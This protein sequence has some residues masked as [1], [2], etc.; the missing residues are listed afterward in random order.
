MAKLNLPVCVPRRAG[1]GNV[2]IQGIHS[3]GKDYEKYSH[4]HSSADG[5][6]Y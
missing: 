6:I 4:N 5:L 3:L 2:Q 1:T